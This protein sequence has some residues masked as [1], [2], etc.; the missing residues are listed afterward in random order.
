MFGSRPMGD[1]L[2]ILW[3]LDKYVLNLVFYKVG[4]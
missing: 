2:E 1:E 3:H 4:L